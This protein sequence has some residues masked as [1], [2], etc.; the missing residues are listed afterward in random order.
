MDRSA[1]EIYKNTLGDRKINNSDPHI[2]EDDVFNAN[3][4]ND[5]SNFPR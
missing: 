1:V 5:N 2:I 3:L 4:S